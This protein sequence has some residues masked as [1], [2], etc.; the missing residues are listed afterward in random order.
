MSGHHDDDVARA[1]AGVGVEGG[2]QLVVEDL[3]LAL[4]TVRDMEADRSIAR[5][6]DC[7]PV[8]SRV[9]ARG[10]ARGCRPA[11]AA[12]ASPRQKP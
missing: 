9:S 8:R 2:E 5:R 7:R 1:Q 6:I 3:D 10:A 4:R 12:A 11:V